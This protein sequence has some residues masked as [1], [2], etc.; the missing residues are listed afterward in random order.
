MEFCPKCGSLLAPAVVNGKPSLVCRKCGF[1]KDAA[2]KEGYM[3]KEV[4][5]PEK[6]EKLVVI[7]GVKERE[8]ERIEEEREF[9]KEYYEILLESMESGEGE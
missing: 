9:L 7:E 8:K 4:V 3:V 1:R 5:S 6:R 2:R